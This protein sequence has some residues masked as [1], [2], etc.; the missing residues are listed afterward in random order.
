MTVASC[1]VLPWRTAGLSVAG[2]ADGPWFVDVGA[3]RPLNHFPIRLPPAA[4][5]R[6]L[7]PW[8]P[9]NTVN[10]YAAVTLVTHMTQLTTRPFTSSRV[11]YLL[12]RVWSSVTTSSVPTRR[13][14]H[15]PVPGWTP[16]RTG[17]DPG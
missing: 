14:W 5:P 7:F 8:Q 4:E 1:C 9:D 12:R 10:Y 13:R 11:A 2:A 6:V 3:V 15:P 16:V 17:D